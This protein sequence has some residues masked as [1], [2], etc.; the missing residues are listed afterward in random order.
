MPLL[1]NQRHLFDIPREVAYLNCAFMAPQLKAAHAA[2]E[3]ALRQKAQ[4]WRMTST[5]FFTQSEETRALF[6]RLIGAEADDIAFIPSVSYGM[7]VARL[8]LPLRAG[9]T[10][11]IAAEEFPSGVYAW[12]EAARESGAEM[13]VVPRPADGDWTAAMLAAIDGRTGVVLASQTHWICGG[14]MDLVALSA[15]AK[16]VG[17]ALVLDITQSGGVVPLNVK[18]I[19]PDF[20]AAAS[21]KWLMGPYALGFLYAAPRHHRGVPL[22]H[23]WVNREG[24]QDFRRLTECREEFQPGARRFDMGERSSFH[25]MPMARAA[26]EQLLAWGAND[27]ARTLG[28]M[29]AHIAAEAS[30]RFGAEAAPEA[31]RSPH[32]LGLRLPGGLPEGFAQALAARNVH[33]SLRGDRVRVT[34]HLYN[35]DE[36]IGRLFEALGDSLRRAA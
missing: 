18:T 5:D 23:G 34:P 22:E 15:K 28:H 35:D 12:R 3:E 36:D 32:Y 27:I 31:L 16:A 19:D 30:V 9:Q 25:L 14:H 6:A 4:P 10:V 2:G 11:V 8:N 26:L 7:A 29:T 13:V 1:T 20:V 33:V 24:A 21:Y 17:A